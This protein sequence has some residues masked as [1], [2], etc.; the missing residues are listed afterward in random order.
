MTDNYF[1]YGTAQRWRYSELAVTRDCTA[2]ARE[3]ALAGNA[4]QGAQPFIQLFRRTDEGYEGPRIL[5][6]HRSTFNNQHAHPHPRFTP[7]GRYVLYLTD[8]SNMYLV[9]VGISRCRCWRP[10]RR[11][12]RTCSETRCATPELRGR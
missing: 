11:R 9:P 7:D 3:P 8:Y 10:I 2:W 4:W 5:A 12:A 6:W 1:I